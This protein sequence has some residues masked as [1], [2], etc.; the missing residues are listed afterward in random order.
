MEGLKL[1]I[2]KKKKKCRSL[3]FI[4]GLPVL[5][6]WGGLKPQAS[7]SPKYL[8]E[9]VNYNKHVREKQIHSATSLR[10]QQEFIVF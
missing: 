1:L 7:E 2:I 3:P 6:F 8:Y 10:N 5:V 9:T 4:Y